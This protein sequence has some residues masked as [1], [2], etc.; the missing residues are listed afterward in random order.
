MALT[1][2]QL[3]GVQFIAGANRDTYTGKTAKQIKATLMSI[4]AAEGP[5][6]AVIKKER[7][8]LVRTI[9]ST[10]KGYL[11][12]ECLWEYLKK[13]KELSDDASIIFC[14]EKVDNSECYL[15]IVTKGV[16]I[17]DAIIPPSQIDLFVSDTIQASEGGFD[18][19]VFG[20]TPFPSD[21]ET[22]YGIGD[23][24]LEPQFIKSYTVLDAP[25]VDHVSPV[26][27]HLL[28][29]IPSALIK[30]R[31]AIPKGAVYTTLLVVFFAYIGHGTIEPK[32]VVQQVSNAVT[33]VDHYIGFNN[34]LSTPTH[35]DILTAMGRA[36]EE[37]APLPGVAIQKISY[38]NGKKHLVVTANITAASLAHINKRLKGSPWKV[39]FTDGQVVFM[40]DTSLK[41][42][43]KPTQIHPLNTS[44]ATVL[45]GVYLINGAVSIGDLG[46]TR[47]YAERALTIKYEEGYFPSYKTDEIIKTFTSLPLHI[48][49]I[50]VAFTSR[51]RSEVITTASLLGE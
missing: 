25:C 26:K 38:Q 45:D 35:K 50:D 4:E 15:L 37:L 48:K 20:N 18:I 23:I 16:V 44:L 33:V 34:K 14:E 51:S 2:F 27:S 7:G 42:R 46:A 5:T 28:L 1:Y 8:G 10:L 6:V 49:S 31:M 9:T 21:S 3:K 36:Y 22:N 43:K 32:E 29:P 30:A 19:I 47:H 24:I 12:G 11:F 41:N 13:E 39:S 40:M 17:Y